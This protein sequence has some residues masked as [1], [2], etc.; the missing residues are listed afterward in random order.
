MFSP[1]DLGEDSERARLSRSSPWTPVLSVLHQ[2]LLAGIAVRRYVIKL[3]IALHNVFPGWARVRKE[4][5]G[6]KFSLY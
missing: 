6:L 1:G 5:K 4:K 3:C 2:S